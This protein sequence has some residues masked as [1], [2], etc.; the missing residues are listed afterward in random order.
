[1]PAIFVV[2]ENEELSSNATVESVHKALLERGVP[3][4]YHVIPG[5]T[6]YGV[7]REGFEEATRASL[8]WFDRH[9]KKSAD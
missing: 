1:M 4:R 2:A 7:Y 5:I 9:L 3:S 6:H 8:E